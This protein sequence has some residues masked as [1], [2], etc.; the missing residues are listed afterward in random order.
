MVTANPRADMTSSDTDTGKPYGSATCKQAYTIIKRNPKPHASCNHAR[1]SAID[2]T[3]HLSR[4]QAGTA[5]EHTREARTVVVNAY[6][7]L[8][9][10]LVGC[11]LRKFVFSTS[12]SIMGSHMLL[13]K[14]A[15][16]GMYSKMPKMP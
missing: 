13:L 14:M 7:S 6:H 9:A 8:N 3:A 5:A 4:K 12:V 10:A 1:A 15:S 16:N 2:E 11:Q